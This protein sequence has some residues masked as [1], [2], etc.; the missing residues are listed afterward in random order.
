MKQNRDVYW[1]Q[2]GEQKPMEHKNAL[3]NSVK[4]LLIMKQNRDVYW[5]QKEVN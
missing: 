3:K 4:V 1:S 2:K 5:S